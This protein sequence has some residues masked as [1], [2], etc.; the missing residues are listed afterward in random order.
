MSYLAWGLVRRPP[1]ISGTWKGD[2]QISTTSPVGY[3]SLVKA[4]LPWH[5]FSL[6]YFIKRITP[7]VKLWMVERINLRLSSRV[8]KRKKKKRNRYSLETWFLQKRNRHSLHKKRVLPIKD[9][10]DLL[11]FS[12]YIVSSSFEI[13]WTGAHQDPLS[14]RF[15]RQ[16]YWSGFRFFLQ[17]IFVT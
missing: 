16:E 14:L 12:R 13:Q 7:K 11:L 1:C 15:P 6:T 17:G 4:G 3:C 8:K 5:S 2:T 9:Y 10:I